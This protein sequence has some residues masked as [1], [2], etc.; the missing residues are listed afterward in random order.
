ME[1]AAIGSTQVLIVLDDASL[2]APA[3]AEQQMSAAF[4]AG[5]VSQLSALAAASVRGSRRRSIKPP[6]AYRMFRKLGIM[7]GTVDHD[8]FNDLKA[9]M[10]KG[11]DSMHAAGVLSLIRPSKVAATSTLTA[12]TTWGIREL[13]VNKLWDQGLTGKG[14]IVGHLDTGVDGQHPALKSAI[15]SFVE[16]DPMGFPVKPSP[17]AFDSGEHGTHTAGTIAGRAV[18][19]K[20]IGVAPSSVLASALVIEGGQVLA[21]VAAGLEW[22]LDQK[23][24]L[25]SM[26]LGIRG[27]NPFFTRIVTVLRANGVLPIFAAGNEGPGTSRSPGNY[28]EALSVGAVDK[29][30]LV[31]D[32]SSSQ[33]F[34]RPDDPLVPDLTGPGVG[35]ISAKPGKGYQSMDGTSMATPHIAGLAALLFEAK[36]D[37]TIDHVERAIRSSCRPLDAG[38]AG[39]A[40]TGLPDAVVALKLLLS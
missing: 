24:R 25:I 18:K 20:S 32:F 10:G 21:R 29:K 37:A 23:V 4:R 19:G 12:K 8:G 3:A 39:R 28:A 17:A 35:I 22:A 31:A 6:P 34:Q 2:K 27:F 16:M 1:L 5:E 36:P 30:Q 38:D 15:A 14:V 40:A 26:S 13:K 11:V 7:I 33:M 9:S